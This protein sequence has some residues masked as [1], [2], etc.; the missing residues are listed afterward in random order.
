MDKKTSGKEQE[1]QEQNNK[2]ESEVVGGRRQLKPNVVNIS[3]KHETV[4]E[5]CNGIRRGRRCSSGRLR[6]LGYVTDS[7]EPG[8][9]ADGRMRVRSA[10][11]VRLKRNG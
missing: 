7:S 5:D 10:H 2:L 11:Q 9:N 6:E 1:H 4:K 8:C 3:F